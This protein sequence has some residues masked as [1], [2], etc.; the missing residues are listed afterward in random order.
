MGYKGLTEIGKL[1]SIDNI[2]LKTLNLSRCQ[3]TDSLTIDRDVCNQLLI[4]QQLC[5]MP[6]NNTLTVLYLDGNKFTGDGIHILTGLMHLCPSLEVL[7]TED[8]AISSCDLSQLLDVLLQLKISSDICCNLRYW[9]LRSNKIDDEGVSA[10]MERRS[11]SLF[12]SLGYDEFELDGNPIS[13]EM[14]MALEREWNRNQK[15]RN[16]DIMRFPFNFT[17]C[18]E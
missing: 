6:R 9:Y 5:Q 10:F 16:C 3:L 7:S 4:G 2:Q 13:D 15:V 11:W 18:I 8:C 17:T 14:T 1:L 12:P